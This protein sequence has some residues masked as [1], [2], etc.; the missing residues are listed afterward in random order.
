MSK[1][2]LYE[3]YDNF[4][5][6]NVEFLGLLNDTSTSDYVVQRLRTKRTITRYTVGP[7]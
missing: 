7:L 6:R 4:G 2:R 5:V 3:Y 1:R